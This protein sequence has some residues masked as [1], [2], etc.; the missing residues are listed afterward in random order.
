MA[1]ASHAKV[2][3]A[4][5]SAPLFVDKW[6]ATALVVAVLFTVTAIALALIE[7]ASGWDHFFRAWVVGMVLNFGFCC[8]GLTL[9]MLQYVTGGK[10][11]LLL[12]RPLEAMS[13]TLPLIIVYWLA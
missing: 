4:D 13:R 10:W 1:H 8:G 2:L 9:L 11:G 7:G 3:P 12:R 6:R 5:L